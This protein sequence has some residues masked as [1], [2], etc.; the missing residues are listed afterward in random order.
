MNGSRWSGQGNGARRR[1]EA[2]RPQAPEVAVDKKG[3]RLMAGSKINHALL[4]SHAVEVSDHER[5]GMRWKER[6]TR[7]FIVS[8]TP[9]Y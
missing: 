1:A 6:T 5:V 8:R 3:C 2:L 7:T 4:G 9:L